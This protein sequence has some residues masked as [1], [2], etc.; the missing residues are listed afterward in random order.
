[1]GLDDLLV[2]KASDCANKPGTDKLDLIFLVDGSTSIGNSNFTKILMFVSEVIKHLD[3]AENRSRVGIVQFNG[4]EKTEL[5]L[6]SIYSKTEVLDFVQHR[7]SYLTGVTLTGKAIR[8]VM[9]K[10]FTLDTVSYYL[11]GSLNCGNNS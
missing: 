7:I 8:Y 9:S 2:E 5:H 6:N 4:R 1:M 10:E 3:L 11:L